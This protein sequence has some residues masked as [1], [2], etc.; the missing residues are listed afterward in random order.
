MRKYLNPFGDAVRAG[1]IPLTSGTQSRVAG[2]WGP[3]CDRAAFLGLEF[4]TLDEPSAVREVLSLS[5]KSSFSYVVT[6]NVDHLVR[7]HRQRDDASLWA[8]YRSATLRLCDS[9]I[10]GALALFSGVKLAPVPGSDL[11]TRIL[12]T[13]DDLP[14]ALVVG[15]NEALMNDLRAL[16]PRI[17]W[18]HHAPPYGLARNPAAQRE[19]ADFVENCSAGLVFFAI[20][21]PQ[22]ELICATLAA[23]RRTRGVALCIGASLEFITGAKRRA[24]RW[25]QRAGLEW[26]FRLASEPGRL[27]RRYLIEGPAIF[28]VW[29]RWR[30]SSSR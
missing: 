28:R 24:P 9:R 29:W 27:W 25:M 18:F 2:P 20:G 12:G 17:T 7:L 6:P 21:S 4:D 30:F 3:D 23:R 5:R 14:T 16:Y 13:Q 22:S 19:V 1:Q 8:A 11:T 15:G 26:L 10:L